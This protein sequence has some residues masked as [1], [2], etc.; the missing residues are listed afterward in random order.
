MKNIIVS[1]S[2]LAADPMRFGQEAAS[3]EAAGADWH[4]VDVMDG[5]FVPN[6]TYGLP[7]IEAL[8]KTS[9]IPLDVH[10]MISNPDQVAGDYVSAGADILVFHIEASTHPHRT[11][12]KIKSSGAKAGI[13]LNPGTPTSAVSQLIADADLFLVM[14]VNPGFG[15]Q[16]FIHGAVDKIS[17]LKAM[18]AKAGRSGEVDI[19]VDGGVNHETVGKIRA[20]GATAL[21]AGTYV[22]GAKDRAAAIAS[23]RK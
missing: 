21:V 16:K 10:I 3:V 6:L 17:E 20:A 11:I 23:L 1:P 19:E 7:F 5:H 22:Y 13:A 8:K 14:T 15:G 12:Q 9:K 2:L 4:H 18:V